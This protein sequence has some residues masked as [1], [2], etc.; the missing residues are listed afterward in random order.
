MFT[1]RR[2]VG[3]HA[4]TESDDPYNTPTTYMPPAD[5]AGAP[6]AVYGWHTPS[7]TEPKLAGHPERVVVDIELF[8]PTGLDIRPGGLIDLPAGP[9]GQFEVIGWDQDYDQG[10]NPKFTPGRVVNLR[11]TEG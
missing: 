1:P 7:T 6:L 11:R 5:E 4:P 2:T 3:Y 9:E 8:A 10:P